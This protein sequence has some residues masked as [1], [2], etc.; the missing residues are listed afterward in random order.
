MRCIAAAATLASSQA[1][2]EMKQSRNPVILVFAFIGVCAVLYG[3]WHL[4]QQRVA[5]E[6]AQTLFSAPASSGPA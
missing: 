2:E 3:A 6:Q 4:Y 5:A 1:G